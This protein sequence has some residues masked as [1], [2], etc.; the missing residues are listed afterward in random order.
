M[1][2]PNSSQPTG[3]DDLTGRIEEEFKSPNTILLK[4][5]EENNSITE[6][7]FGM[8]FYKILSCGKLIKLIEM[9]GSVH[10]I[11]VIFQTDGQ[12]AL[13]QTDD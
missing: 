12:V 11:H 9:E 2:S 4:E 1:R 7:D 13:I 8:D 3:S 5:L 10:D 6:S